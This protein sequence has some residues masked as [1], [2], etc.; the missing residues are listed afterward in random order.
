MERFKNTLIRTQVQ[1]G[2]VNMTSNDIFLERTDEKEIQSFIKKLHNAYNNRIVNY[3]E[4][5]ETDL[6]RFMWS[7]NKYVS[8][9]MLCVFS[10][11]KFYPESYIFFA[12]ENSDHDQ[13]F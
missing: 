8:L 2:R 5:K 9:Y 4:I 7:E 13:F 11:N 10:D 6:S 3:Y 1:K 12:I